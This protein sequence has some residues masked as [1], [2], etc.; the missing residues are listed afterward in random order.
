MQTTKLEPASRKTLA[1]RAAAG[2]DCETCP[3]CA[4]PA[5]APYRR[6]VDS[7]IVEGCIDAAH[8]V[9]HLVG[10]SREWHYRKV[11]VAHRRAVAANLEGK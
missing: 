7:R 4:R 8:S 1:I 6:I 3:I 11:A 9:A 2:N 5:N 10:D